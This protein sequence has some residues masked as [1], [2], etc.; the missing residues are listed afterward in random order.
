MPLGLLLRHLLRHLDNLLQLP[1]P[2]LLT[3]SVGEALLHD[4]LS[5]ADVR[6]EARQA[7]NQLPY[8]QSWALPLNGGAAVR[9]SGDAV[10]RMRGGGAAARRLGKAATSAGEW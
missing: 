9:W 5:D 4:N 7:G 10:V 1:I 8:L 3:A 2:A 6:A